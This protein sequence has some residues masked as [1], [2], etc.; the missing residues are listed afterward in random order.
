MRSKSRGGI[1][2]VKRKVTMISAD[3]ELVKSLETL[4][5]TTKKLNPQSMPVI[6]FK[7]NWTLGLSK[8]LPIPIDIKTRVM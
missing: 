5:I 3:R 1:R 7:V 2:N 4:Y 6:T 8:P